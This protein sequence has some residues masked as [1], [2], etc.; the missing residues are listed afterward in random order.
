MIRVLVKLF[1]HLQPHR[2]LGEAQRRGAQI[3]GPRGRE[4]Q[5]LAAR[6]ACGAPENHVDSAISRRIKRIKANSIGN[7]LLP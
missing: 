1:S 4:E 3:F 7:E 6:G 5:R 2:P